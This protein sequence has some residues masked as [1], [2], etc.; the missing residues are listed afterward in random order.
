MIIAL[1]MLAW[2]LHG[3]GRRRKESNKEWVYRQ[4]ACVHSQ[5]YIFKNNNYTC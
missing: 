5:L 4:I 3:G 1:E 2:K